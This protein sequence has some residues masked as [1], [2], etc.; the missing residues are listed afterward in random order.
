[1]S[2][3]LFRGDLAG[4]DP[5]LFELTEI[6]SERQYRKLILIPSESTSPRAVREALASSFHNI[7][8][9]GYPAE[10][11]RWLTE[12][13]ILDY[14]NRLSENRRYSD[15]RYYKGVEYANILEALARRRCAELFATND[16]S[17][18]DL[19]VNVQALSGGPANN[20][21]YHALVN[22]GD[23]VMGMELLHGGHLSHGS[24]VNRSG[25]Y[26]NIVSYAVDAVTE[27]IDYDAVEVLALQ[28][29][30]KM[31]IAGIS[32]YPWMLDWRRFRAIAD[33]AGAYLMADIAH[34]AGL[35]AAGVYDSPV[36]Y[37]DVISFTT[38]K[39]LCG[40]RGAVILTANRL[41]ARKIDRAV[42]PGEQGGPHVNVFAA[43]ALAFK[44]AKTKQF[45]QLQF[46]V[47]ENCASLTNRL[48]ERGFKIAFNGSDTHLLNLDTKT[49]K[50][51]DGAYL[52]GD[53]AA[54]I[55]D[56]AGIVV[57][58]NTI[59]GDTSALRPTGIRMG[60]HWVTQRGF[61]Q[62]ESIQLADAI[63]DLLQ[64]TEPYYQ[65]NLLRAKV[66]F[67]VLENTKI[68]IR[69]LALA[70]GI[71]FDPTHY[72]YPHFT[73]LDDSYLGNWVNFQIGGERVR[74][75]LNMVL[76][77]DLDAL[78]EGQSQPTSV[79]TPQGDVGCVL[80][81]K[82]GGAFVLSVPAEHGGLVAA[83]LRALSDGYV[84]FDGDIEKKIPGPVWVRE[85][86]QNQGVEITGDPVSQ[87]KPYF[88]GIGDHV[89][90]P[91]PDFTWTEGETSLKR[92]PL[93]DLHVALG[94]K[95]VPFA[96]WEMPVR[97]TSVMEEHVAVREAAGLFDVSHMGVYQVEGLDS[98]AFLDCVC[99]NDI[100]S[101]SVGQSLYTHFLDPDGAVIDDLLVY[102]R[103][104]EKYLVVVNASN[105]D[106]DWTW[107]SAV[108]AGGVKV[109]QTRPWA[110]VYGRNVV[111]RNLRDPKAGD[112]MRVDLALQGP[113]SRE[114]LLAMGVEEVDRK[115]ILKLQ[116]T[117][118][119]EATVGGFDLVVSRTGYTGEKMAF[120]L[121][122]HPERAGNLFQTLLQI[123]EP[124]GLKPI[125]LGARDSLRIEAGLPL[126][127]HE[128]SGPSDFGVGDAGFGAYV[129]TYKPWFIGRD[130]FLAQE[131][132]RKAVVVRFRFNEKGVRMAHQGDPVINKRGK[133][134]GV[135]TS[136]AADKDGFLL[137]QAYVDLKFS[138]ENTPIL[139]YQGASGEEIKAPAEML[140][141]DRIFLP[142][143]ATII[144]RFP[145]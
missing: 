80:S 16:I 117:E 22:P 98:V 6:E 64:A 136:C 99:G 138:E 42:F 87:Q 1:M 37:A 145:K 79:H 96:G 46:Q 69:E 51:K 124:F 101:L 81:S 118:L 141:G 102:R 122:V 107:L 132:Q 23:T 27:R 24:P 137:G 3:Y 110:R 92:T 5:V 41:L 121:F 68:K 104:E 76:S 74:P 7:Y 142:A 63:A 130:A 4:L 143:A 40:P 36:G 134:V 71:D 86:D 100:G 88:V 77:S 21:I 19:Y 45:K 59:P 129:K 49:I 38:H 44:L 83:W 39:S 115:K 9:E 73:Y 135:V 43:M 58:R 11:T 12:G 10:E 15:P 28:H 14:P 75:F 120:E 61:T 35:V 108:K 111:L 56:I 52:G 30:P 32:S 57:N 20:A 13:E 33:K 128:M 84:Q 119:C 131:K 54:R 34:V 78:Q 55:L 125:G 8:A 123:G 109:D 82:S 144:R 66:D 67:N 113:R 31:I 94:A 85:T 53:L 89:G 48:S 17:A 47:I 70:A 106:K 105:D 116:R 18:D 2:D 139:I 25:K 133:V 140:M 65:G 114:I 97:Y 93:Y 95:M 26:Y 62:R 103:D 127:G 72:G 126:Y 91:L 90:D 29:K 112:E 50:G 60:T